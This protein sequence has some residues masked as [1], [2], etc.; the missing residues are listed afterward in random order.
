MAFTCDG[1]GR[2]APGTPEVSPTGRRLCGGC[3]DQLL[4]LA[5]GVV[6]GGG[7][8]GG[9]ATAGWFTRLR[10]RRWRRSR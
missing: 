8:P 5:A 1:C 7:V 4:G 3:H 9:V 2:R 6:A 10:G